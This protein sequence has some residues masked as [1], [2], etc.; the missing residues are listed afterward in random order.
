MD[1]VVAMASAEGRSTDWKTALQELA[2]EHG[3]GAPTYEHVSTGPDHDKRFEAVA[4][5]GERLFPGGRPVQEARRAGRRAARPRGAR[6]GTRPAGAR[7]TR[8]MPEL[9]EVEVVRARPGAVVTGRRIDA[10]TVLHPRP[11]RR[12]PGGPDD[13]AATL[14]A[15]PSPNRG[16]A[17]STCGCRSPTATR[18]WPTW[19]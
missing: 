8:L 12:H 6:R 2:A 11:V 5:V 13:F 10:V 3:L 17:A 7:P 9:P 1:P 16:A 15:A 14:P 4:V 19:A 18:C